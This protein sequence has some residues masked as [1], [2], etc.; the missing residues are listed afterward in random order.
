MFSIACIV[1][2]ICSVLHSVLCL[3][4]SFTRSLLNTAPSLAVALLP[5]WSVIY[6]KKKSSPVAKTILY[7]ELGYAQKG[8]CV[9][10]HV[11]E[12][13]TESIDSSAICFVCCLLLRN[14]LFGNHFCKII[15]CA[16]KY[17][18]SVSGALDTIRITIPNRITRNN[19]RLWCTNYG[20]LLKWTKSV[21]FSF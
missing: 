11:C 1:L 8:V 4:F 2:P 6:C 19:R 7:L 12:R 5:V 3:S 20:G 17:V 14:Y 9:T 21:A 13:E 16:F 10:L 18:V 15:P